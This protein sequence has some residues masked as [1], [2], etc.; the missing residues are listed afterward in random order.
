MLMLICDW[1]KP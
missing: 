1:W